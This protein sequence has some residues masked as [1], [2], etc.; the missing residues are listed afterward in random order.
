MDFRQGECTLCG[1]CRAVC[2]HAAELFDAHLAFRHHAQIE[3]GCLTHQGVDCQ[4][5]RDHCPTTAI[6][7]RPRIGGPF[8]PDV[9]VDACNGCG[10]CIA[11]CP[12]DAVSVAARKELADA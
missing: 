6:R 7:F 1:E 3:V 12:V 2:P 5:C 9:D 8:Q 10:A 4:A 11:V